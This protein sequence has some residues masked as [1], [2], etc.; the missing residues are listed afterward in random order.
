MTDANV[1]ERLENDHPLINYIIE[2]RT[3][4]KLLTTYVDALPQLV[5]NYTGFPKEAG[6]TMEVG[7]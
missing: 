4:S 3:I 1:L 5:E 2:Y 7:Q 6:K